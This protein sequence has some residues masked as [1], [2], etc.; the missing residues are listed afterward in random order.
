MSLTTDAAMRDEKRVPRMVA[1]ELMWEGPF[2]VAE[3]ALTDNISAH[4]A[5]VITKRKLEVGKNLSIASLEGDLRSEARVVYRLAQPD[6]TF[7]IGLELRNPS[8]RW[9]N[10]SNGEKDRR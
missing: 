2:T 9:H 3:V 5:R 6:H 1:V 8:G 10:H 4:G 7:A